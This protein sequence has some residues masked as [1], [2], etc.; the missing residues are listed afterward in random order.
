MGVSN[1]L[2]VTAVEV[3]PDTDEVIRSR[4]RRQ[5]DTSA[6]S[7]TAVVAS[8]DAT[9]E[10]SDSPAKKAPRVMSKSA[11]SKASRTWFDKY[12]D[13]KVS[14]ETCVEKLKALMDKFHPE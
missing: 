2:E 10:Q 13:G 9:I 7:S 11:Y 1:E 12:T 4:K 3:D 14:A 6:S 5:S 8:T